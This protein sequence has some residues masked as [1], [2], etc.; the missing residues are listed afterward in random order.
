MEEWDVGRRARGDEASLDRH[1]ADERWGKK[2]WQDKDV[3]ICRLKPEQRILF[4]TSP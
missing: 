2:R 3:A 1:G 4:E